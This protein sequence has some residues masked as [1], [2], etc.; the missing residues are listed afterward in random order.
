MSTPDKNTV[1][2]E[3]NAAKTAITDAANAAFIAAADIVIAEMVAQGKFKVTLP[4]VKPASMTAVTAY[5][6][7][8]QYG[9]SMDNCDSWGR[10]DWPGLY[11]FPYGSPFYPY[12]YICN[13]QAQC[14]ITIYWSAS[15]CFY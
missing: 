6:R 8:L 1:N 7:G 11:S 14:S 4:V 3:A 2:T 10:A 12:N 15:N 5:Y 9:V 13:C